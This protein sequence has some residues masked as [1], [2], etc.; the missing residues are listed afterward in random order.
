MSSGWWHEQ[1]RADR[2]KYIKIHWNNIEESMHSQFRKCKGCSN[3]GSPYDTTS[4]MQY[5]TWAF[6]KSRDKPSMTKIGCPEDEVWPS[7]ECRLGQ[8]DGMNE[9][10]LFEI[11]KLYCSGGGGK[12]TNKPK[13][14][15]NPD[16][17]KH[18]AAWKDQGFCKHSY[19]RYMK[20]NCARSCG[21]P[22]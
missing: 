3:Q 13:C 14:R 17:K 8:Y 15:N 16:V 4:V 5:G 21:C 20:K 18:C 1:S 9:S 22:K 6:Q 19:V 2:D 7:K 12:P 10:D 11:N